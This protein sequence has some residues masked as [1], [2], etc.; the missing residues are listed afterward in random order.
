MSYYD[1][2][3]TALRFARCTSA[4]DT[5]SVQVVASSG[6]QGQYTNLFFD[7]QNRPT[8]FFYDRSHAK[9]K[10]ALLS[11]GSWSLSNLAPGGQEIHVTLFGA[12]LAYSNADSTTDTVYVTIL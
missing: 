3:D 6:S 4:W 8:I 2:Q 5:W 9:A 10:R 12:N 1:S 11:G 7:S